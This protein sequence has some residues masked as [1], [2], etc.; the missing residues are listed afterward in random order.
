VFFRAPRLSRTTHRCMNHGT[1][2]VNPCSICCMLCVWWLPGYI[3]RLRFTTGIH[4]RLASCFFRESVCVH[5]RMETRLRRLTL[6]V[7]SNGKMKELEYPD[8]CP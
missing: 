4:F 6:V 2:M 1:R 5:R 3:L 8:V 7:R